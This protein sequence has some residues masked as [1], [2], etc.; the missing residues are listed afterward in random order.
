MKGLDERFREIQAALKCFGIESMQIY[1][2]RVL[3]VIM[4][5]GNLEI[6][7]SKTL[8]PSSVGEGCI[9]ENSELLLAQVGEF[10]VLDARQIKEELE[11]RQIQI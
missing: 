8:K 2:W 6:E 4:K 9:S 11:F 5:L 7:G 10:L 3:A 1:L